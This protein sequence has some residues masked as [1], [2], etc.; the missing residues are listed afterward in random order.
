MEG[1]GRLGSHRELTILG[2]F[3]DVSVGHR[4]GDVNQSIDSF[5]DPSL[6][7]SPGLLASG[8]HQAS[9]KISIVPLIAAEGCQSFLDLAGA[10]EDALEYG[11]HWGANSGVENVII[12]YKPRSGS[13]QPGPEFSSWETMTKTGNLV[14]R[15]SDDMGGNYTIWVDISSGTQRAT[16]WLEI[17]GRWTTCPISL[18]WE[19]DLKALGV[20]FLGNDVVKIPLHLWMT[21][22][23]LAD[24]CPASP[25]EMGH[26]LPVR[27]PVS[28]SVC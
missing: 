14:I 4:L 23:V 11:W 16:G 5:I 10:L 20:R 1:M 7:S 18:T 22:G 6:S 19:L 3:T 9:G 28:P 13:W 27:A 15:N 2:V 21:L 8:I 24:G 26:P 12:S 25:T 17:R